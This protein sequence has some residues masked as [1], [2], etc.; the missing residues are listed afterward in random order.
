MEAS[1]VVIRHPLNN[2]QPKVP[3]KMTLCK[4]RS[5]FYKTEGLCTRIIF[6]F[7]KEKVFNKKYNFQSPLRSLPPQCQLNT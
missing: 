2:I 1:D 3:K 6:L 5:H 4:E 7:C